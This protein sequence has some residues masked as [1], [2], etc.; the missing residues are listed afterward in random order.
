[1][2]NVLF[3]ISLLMIGSF[4]SAQQLTLQKKMTLDQFVGQPKDV[5]VSSKFK[6]ILYWVQTKSDSIMI[7]SVS[8]RLRTPIG[9]WNTYPTY[10]VKA[11]QSHLFL[12]ESANTLFC[13][14]HL[15]S[16]QKST[17]F[18]Q[19]NYTSKALQSSQTLDSTQ[20][21]P[22]IASTYGK[23][24]W[25]QVG[26]LNPSQDSIQISSVSTAQSS[27]WTVRNINLPLPVGIYH[28][29][30]APIKQA[31][32]AFSPDG[33]VGYVVILTHID[34]TIDSSANL[35]P[36]VYYTSNGGQSWSG[37]KQ[38]PVNQAAKAY[39]NTTLNYTIGNKLGAVVNNTGNLYID[40]YLAPIAQPFQMDH[41][42]FKPVF[43]QMDSSTVNLV[44]K[45]GAHVPNSMDSIGLPN[46]K[47]YLAEGDF[48]ASRDTI[49]TLLAFSYLLK[50]SLFDSYDLVG[51][52]Q[53]NNLN[54][55]PFTGYEFA[56]TGKTVFEGKLVSF[57]VPPVLHRDLHALEVVR[58]P[59]LIS[60]LDSSNSLDSPLLIGLS[61]TAFII[62][63]IREVF[64]EISASIY[65]NPAS[66]Q[67]TVDFQL[68]V[69]TKYKL[70]VADVFGR[71]VLN[72]FY[73]VA[74]G[75]NQKTDLAVSNHSPAVYL[76]TIETSTQKK[77]L[78]FIRN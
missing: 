48:S 45:I 71:K 49:G 26:F 25:F 9:N 17:Y 75:E 7:D 24:A 8:N 47:K 56:L 63:G 61:S 40:C 67:L 14:T 38:Y 70:S 12:D 68:P 35:L 78:R 64:P 30:K 46:G 22:S 74:T 36:V 10:P 27:G 37:P 13:Q 29:L 33:Q 18:G 51:Y 16:P 57:R 77:T 66:D 20:L 69:G 11:K 73:G 23:D 3:A 59:A 4:S 39:Y 65:P 5:F 21:R 53:L 44:W 43:I 41:S 31:A 32:I 50:D 19:W 42:Q 1:M 60:Y 58:F 55:S 6:P 2:R 52:F 62:D 72:D 54:G 28:G 34:F 76:L 15:D